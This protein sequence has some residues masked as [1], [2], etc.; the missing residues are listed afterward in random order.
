MIDSLLDELLLHSDLLE[1]FTASSDLP[2]ESRLVSYA[3]QLD[4]LDMQLEELIW[5][6][7]N[8]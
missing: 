8:R 5:A 4:L 1:S 7:S 6:N 2:V 3:N